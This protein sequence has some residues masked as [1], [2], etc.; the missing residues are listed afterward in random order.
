MN[1]SLNVPQARE[2]Y[3]GCC[4]IET[5]KM[6]PQYTSFSDRLVSQSRALALD[7]LRD[8]VELV[9]AETVVVGAIVWKVSAVCPIRHS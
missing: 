6:L 3:S 1:K 5:S 7:L 9:D 8:V 4:W 2:T